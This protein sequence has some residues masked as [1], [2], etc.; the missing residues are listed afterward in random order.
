M[1]VQRRL[2]IPPRAVGGNIHPFDQ[3]SVRFPVLPNQPGRRGPAAVG[4]IAMIGGYN[5]MSLTEG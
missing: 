4:M 3:P 5:R 1:L 2:A